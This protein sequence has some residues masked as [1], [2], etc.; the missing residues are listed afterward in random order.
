LIVLC[1]LKTAYSHK[2]VRH[3]PRSCFIKL[4]SHKLCTET[5]P[6]RCYLIKHPLEKKGYI[7]Y[8][9]S[10]RALENYCQA[11]DVLNQYYLMF[12]EDEDYLKTVARVNADAGFYTRSLILNESL[13]KQHPKNEYLIATQ[14][15]A[16]YQSRRPEAALAL[17]DYLKEINPT[18]AQLP[19]LDAMIRT[20][21]QDN[22]SLGERFTDFSFLNLP[23]HI[24]SAFQY[25]HQSDT[26]SI[27]RVPFIMQ[28]YFNPST[29][30]LFKA[31]YEYYHAALNSGLETVDGRTHI[32]DTEYY[33]GLNKVLNQAMQI[34][35]VLGDLAI[36]N[37]HNFIV[38]NLVANLFPTERLNLSLQMVHDLF[39]PLD[40]YNGSPL[41]VSLGILETTGRT[42]ISYKFD[43][44]SSL[45][46]DVRYGSL[47]DGNAYTR[48]VFD[49]SSTVYYGAKVKAALVLDLEWL[50]ALNSRAVGG[51]Y[52][53][54]LY[55][56]YE[57]GVSVDFNATDKLFFQFYL[58]AGTVKDNVT[59]HFGGA[60][61]LMVQSRYALRKSLDLVAGMD[62]IFEQVSP[63]YNE[64]DASL[65]LNWR[66]G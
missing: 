12:G 22:Y 36:S 13:M 59:P 63:S 7:D 3:M 9:E 58:A 51:Y 14:A 41:L 57:L 44:Q 30:L 55:Q 27:A 45:D 60:T 6:Y 66:F 37:H 61:A 20:P 33:I 34:Q 47:S 5:E 1:V 53:P 56:L 28:N 54:S 49:P 43:L 46:F 18:S 35:G 65:G 16:L 42:H 48:L 21:L 2:I 31:Q 38:Y 29:S 32:Q 23:M 17:L 11:M 25:V 15:S 24:P 62:Y 8:A 19:V 26:V 10:E 64:V 50:H 39:R 4:T 52:S 40:I